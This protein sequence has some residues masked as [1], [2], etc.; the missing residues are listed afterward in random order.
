MMDTMVSWEAQLWSQGCRIRQE[1]YGQG[2]FILGIQESE[3][4]PMESEKM[5]VNLSENV[6]K[7]TH[8]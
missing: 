1:E 6:F 8:L 4:I 7:R 5:L 2:K 3:K